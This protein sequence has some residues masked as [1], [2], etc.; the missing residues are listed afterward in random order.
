MN[1]ASQMTEIARNH[2]VEVR[3]ELE[4]GRQEHGWKD[5]YDAPIGD[6]QCAIQSLYHVVKEQKQSEV[7]SDDKKYGKSLMFKA[8]GI[9]IDECPGCFICGGLSR[10]LNNISAFV[11]NK[12]DGEEI[13]S[14]FQQGARLDYRPNE[15]SWIQVKIGACDNHLNE[16]GALAK[17]A[18]DY[19]VLR[20]Y[21]VE[22]CSAELVKE[23]S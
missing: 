11:D 21:D 13:V 23:Q 22:A 10:L 19:G 15:P 9:G 1:R 3:S 5:R 20:R 6:I 7:T 8:R 16:L 2:L 18:S 4:A 14:W 17:A 12:Q